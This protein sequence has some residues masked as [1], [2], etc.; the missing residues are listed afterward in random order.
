MTQT[1]K[2]LEILV[3]DDGSDDGTESIVN[4][5]HHEDASVRWLPGQRA[6]RP[7]VPRN[8]GIR[9]SRGDWIAFLDSDDQWHRDKLEKQLT[10]TQ[11]LGCL[12]VCSNALRVVSSNRSDSCVLAW[13]KNIIGLDDLLRVNQVVCST[14]MIHRS[15]IAATGGFPEDTKLKALE[16]YALWLRVATLTDFAYVNAPLVRYRDE[17]IASVRAESASLLHQRTIVFGNFLRWGV[18]NNV[19]GLPGMIGAISLAVLREFGAAMARKMAL[20]R[21]H[22]T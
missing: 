19:L 11:H 2:P 3:C 10:L 7:A 9:E 13:A 14:A 15:V 16:D 1:M 12:A 4:A 17:P 5:M 18:R 22:G 20:P 6:G 8:R 21:S